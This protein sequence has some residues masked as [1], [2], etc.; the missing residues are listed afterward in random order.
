MTMYLTPEDKDTVSKLHT[1]KTMYRNI[2]DSLVAR[3]DETLQDLANQLTEHIYALSEEIAEL[4]LGSI[5][6]LTKATHDSAAAKF[7]QGDKV[8]CI[9][10]NTSQ[11]FRAREVDKQIGTV[12]KQTSNRLEI[13]VNGHQGILLNDPHRGHESAYVLAEESSCILLD[14]VLILSER[15]SN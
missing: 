2:V 10:A 11:L 8:F 9:V 15:A 13:E 5:Q 7:K 4:E 14:S 12:T 6:K 3:Q 1:K